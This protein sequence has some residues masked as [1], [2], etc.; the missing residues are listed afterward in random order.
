MYWG[1]G[2]LPE[3]WVKVKLHGDLMFVWPFKR[4]GEDETCSYLLQW[5]RG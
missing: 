2:N 1:A 5:V 4:E 3:A